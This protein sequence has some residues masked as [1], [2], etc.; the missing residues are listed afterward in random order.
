MIW[1]FYKIISVFFAINP[2]KNMCRYQFE[3]VGPDHHKYCILIIIIGVPGRPGE[4]GAPGSPGAPGRDGLPGDKGDS[5]SYYITVIFVLRSLA[6]IEKGFCDLTRNM[7]G[8]MH[9]FKVP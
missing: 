5:G 2:S 1:V 3:S 7:C 4:D 8:S 6:K 9:T